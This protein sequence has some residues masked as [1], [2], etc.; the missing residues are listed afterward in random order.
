[1]R[2]LKYSRLVVSR[3][4]GNMLMF[5]HILSLVILLWSHSIGAQYPAVEQKKPATLNSTT[6]WFRSM[7]SSGDL[8]IHGFA[9]QSFITTSDND[10]FGNSDEDGSFG[11]TEIGLNALLRPLPR[12]QISAQGLSRRAGKDNSGIPRLDFA[13]CRLPIILTTNQSIWNPCGTAEKSIWIL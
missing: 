4:Q 11:F 12:L 13:F 8:Q 2:A 6:E 1:M 7:L 3:R 5:K 10:V 9:S